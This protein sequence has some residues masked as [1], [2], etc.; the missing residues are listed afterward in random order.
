[1]ERL[2]N[3]E[4]VFCS[5]ISWDIN[6]T[7]WRK[8]QSRPWEKKEFCLW[9]VNF[10]ITGVDIIIWF[11]KIEKDSHWKPTCD[12]DMWPNND[13]SKL[14]EWAS[15]NSQKN[16]EIKLNAGQTQ[17]IEKNYIYVPKTYSWNILWCVTFNIKWDVS[18]WSWSLFDIVVHKTIPVKIIVT[19]DVYKTQRL[20]DLK[21]SNLNN[22]NTIIKILVWIIWFRLL[23]SI[24]QSI[25]KKTKH[26]HHKK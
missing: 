6:T 21:E 25:N 24:I 2:N 23:I 8:T 11:S 15:L 13:F 19:W 16:I 1:M 22:I 7:K 17:K 26:S 14:I 10:W 5:L 4:M 9:I 3:I 20:D 18:R 12:Q